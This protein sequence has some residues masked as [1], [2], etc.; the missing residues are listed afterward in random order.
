MILM[1]RTAQTACINASTR[2]IELG[3]TIRQLHYSYKT[4]D[5]LITIMNVQKV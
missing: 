1:Q 5:R 3:L 2:R 4:D